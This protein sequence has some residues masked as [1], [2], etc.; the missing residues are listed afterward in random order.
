MILEI[1]LSSVWSVK[2]DP[3]VFFFFTFSDAV[4]LLFTTL[5]SLTSL[6]HTHPFKST[7]IAED[8]L[9][10]APIIEPKNRVALPLKP[11][12]VVVLYIPALYFNN[13]TVLL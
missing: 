5:D 6:L 4:L 3:E 12:G 13:N 10:I 8:I 9:Y 11:R 1:F 2:Y 7:L